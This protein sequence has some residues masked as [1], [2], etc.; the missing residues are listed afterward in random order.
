MEGLFFKAGGCLSPDEKI[1]DIAL[2][3]KNGDTEIIT[4]TIKTGSAA[5][6][7]P[8][9][10]DESFEFFY[11]LSGKLG[12]VSNEQE[13]IPVKPGDS[14]ITARLRESVL[15]KCIEEA[16]VLYVTNKPG[17]DSAACWQDNQPEQQQG[18]GDKGTAI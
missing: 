14:F 18:T 9:D 2:L 17:C 8:A 11:L 16:Q 6:L 3:A 1:R 5:R 12:I 10:D 4:Q 15:L 7:S 13:I